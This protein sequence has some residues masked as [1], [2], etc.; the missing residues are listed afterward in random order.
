MFITTSRNA[1]NFEKKVAKYFSIYLPNVQL[2]PRGK[3]PISKIFLKSCFL[4][5]KYFL[6]VSKFKNFIKLE[7]YKLK[8]DQYFLDKEHLLEIID[9]NHKISLKEIKKINFAFVDKT[10][11]F[12]FIDFENDDDLDYCSVLKNNEI[13]FQLD[14]KDLGFVFKI[15]NI[16]K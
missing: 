3:T 16:S 12:Y 9:L 4:G 1:D 6:K 5:F 11:F 7:I 14:N 10:K 8:G 13:M 2:I 15:I